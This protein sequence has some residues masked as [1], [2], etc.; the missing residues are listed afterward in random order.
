MDLREWEFLAQYL[1]TTGEAEVGADVDA[2]TGATVTSTAIA[3]CVNS[4]VAYVTGA[5]VGSGA[6]SW[7]G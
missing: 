6:T 1:Y 5:D 2:L 7:G 4:A 3:R